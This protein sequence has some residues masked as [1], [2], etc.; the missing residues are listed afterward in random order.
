MSQ[1]PRGRPK[2][3]TK[4]FLT[5]RDR[6]VIAMIDALEAIN[7]QLKFK[8]IAIFA[9]YFHDNLQIK[10]P[11]SPLNYPRQ[12]GLSPQVREMLHSGWT[13]Q[14]WGP[15]K[16]SYN[17]DK[18]DSNVNRI[19]QKMNRIKS[20]PEAQRWRYYMS[21]LWTSL[22]TAPNARVAAALVREVGEEEYVRE[23]LLPFLERFVRWNV[24]G[25]AGGC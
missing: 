16:W 25:G 6:Y 7:P 20:D 11:A 10:V 17:A 9:I 18:I 19:R 15:S 3:S 13:Y 22:L 8:H 4:P 2:G 1:R 5:D 12:L 14:K 23:K 21:R 24:K